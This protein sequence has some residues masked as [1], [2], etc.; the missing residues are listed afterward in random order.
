MRKFYTEPTFSAE[1]AARVIAA[2]EASQEHN[3]AKK[4]RRTLE[5]DRRAYDARVEAQQAIERARADRARN[6]TLTKRQAECLA[7]V[8][9]GKGPHWKFWYWTDDAGVKH[10]RTSCTQSMGGAVNRMVD[11]LIEE[12]MLSGRGREITDAGRERLEAWEAKH[13][14]IG[15]DPQEQAA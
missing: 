10:W 4:V 9:A 7:A 14:R 11:T 2:L 12:G 3:L 8:R 15:P 6:H 5:I 1:E 13:G